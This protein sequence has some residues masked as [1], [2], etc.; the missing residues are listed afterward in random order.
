MILPRMSSE[1]PALDLKTW[2]NEGIL[3]ARLQTGEDRGSEENNMLT[4]SEFE[5]V[6]EEVF[7]FH[8]KRAPGLAIGVA[9][10]DLARDLL[11]PVKGRLNVISET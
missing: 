8:T 2:V 5:K 6:T 3:N 9:M 7:K 1:S 11:G 10:V 4:D